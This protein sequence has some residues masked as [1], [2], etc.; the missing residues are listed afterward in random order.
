MELTREQAAH[1]ALHF[2]HLSKPRPRASANTVLETIRSL[3]SLQ[4]DTIN[5]VERSQHLVLH[6]RLKDYRREFLEGG[7]FKQGKLCEYFTNVAAI[8]PIEDYPYYFYGWHTRRSPNNWIQTFWLPK[9]REYVERVRKAIPQDTAFST[10][11]FEASL[12]RGGRGWSGSELTRALNYLLITGYLMIH[13]RRGSQ[14]FYV[15]RTPPDTSDIDDRKLT[16]FI[17]LGA[18]GS[19]GIGTFREIQ[20]A[21]F[22]P[23]T[24]YKREAKSMLDDGTLLA[25]SVEGRGDDYY[26]LSDRKEE[27]EAALQ[28]QPSNE[29]T[30]LSPFD[31]L[32]INRQRAFNF[33]NFYP[34]FEAYVPKEKRK[35]GYYNMPILCEEKLLGYVDP[36][37]DRKTS[38]MTFQALNLDR[39]PDEKLR[40]A[41]VEEFAR[42]LRF[43]NAEKLE[44]TESQPHSLAQ[45]IQRNVNRVL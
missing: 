5:V 40:S 23:P 3:G 34:R 6:S 14:R 38:T 22:M 7:L 36:K 45:K 43:H 19:M 25:L 24:D 41:L 13:H 20:L 37:L 28:E 39:T 10:D 32:I 9:N 31:N 1:A 4:I 17:L 18:L 30:L 27:I 42:F 29:A 44:V 15:K 16:R 33:F 2:Q 8:I 21:R 26:M 35:Y 12:Q 11:V